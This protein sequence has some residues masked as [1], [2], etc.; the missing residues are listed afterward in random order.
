MSFGACYER[1]L[2]FDGSDPAGLERVLEACTAALLDPVL[3][4]WALAFT[5][6]GAAGGALIGWFRGRLAV[7]LILGA[8]LGPLGWLAMP[9]LP[10]NYVACPSCSCNNRPGAKRCRHCGVDMAAAA[11]VSRR[12]EQRRLDSGRGWG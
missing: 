6:V 2:A 11:Q 4:W 12:A 7:G 5:V 8:A 1:F 9:L 3:W 10:A